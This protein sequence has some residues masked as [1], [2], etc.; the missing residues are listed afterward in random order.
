MAFSPVNGAAKPIELRGLVWMAIGDSNL[1]GP[2]RITL[3]KEIRD[4]GT[5]THAARAM[6]MS[7]KAAWDAIEG[8]NKVAGEPLVLRAAGGRGGGSTRLTRRG[9][10][11]VE[12]FERIAAEHRR[13]LDGLNRQAQ[14]LED[15]L[16]LIRRIDMQTSAR[17]QF[18]GTVTTVRRGTVN[19]EIDIAVAGA[20][21]I[22]AIITH[23]SADRLGLAIGSEVLALIKASSIIVV[24]DAGGARFSARNRLSG[25]VSRLQ[26]G[27]VNTEVV[28]GLPE[29]GGIAAII[30]NE[31][32]ALLGL[33]VGTAASAIFKASSVIV[34]VPS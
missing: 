13:F 33:A 31:S 30:T 8:M 18:L 10:R 4:H 12:N 17:N 1:G 34:G 3:L 32:A 23:E 21:T 11:L 16:L 26:P 25:T 6:K 24:T 20:Q 27:A 29:G 9:E 7:Y 22:V 5:I 28:I 15:D 2:G 19:D 14:G